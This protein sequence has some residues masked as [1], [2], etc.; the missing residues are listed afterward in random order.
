MVPSLIIGH[1]RVFRIPFND[2]SYIGNSKAWKMTKAKN[3]INIT[4]MII[5]LGGFDGSCCHQS[6]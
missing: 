6:T 3:K 4:E 2:F 1:K 5:F